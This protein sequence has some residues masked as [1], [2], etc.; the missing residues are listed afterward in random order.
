MNDTTDILLATFNGASH[1]AAQLDSLL[2]QTEA[3][4]RLLVR[5]DGSS[6]ATPRIIASYRDRY[7]ERIVVIDEGGERLGPAGNFARLLGVATAGRI[8]FC[9]QDDVW[10][11]EKIAVTGRK[12][13]ELEGAAGRET[14]LLVH[15]DLA[16]VDGELRPLAP[17]LWRFQ[18]VDPEKGGGLNRLLVQNCATGCTVMI[19]RALRDLALPIPPG[20]MMHDWWLALV[21]AAFGRIGHVPEPTV[22]YRQHGANDTGARR[23]S[24]SA[25]A[26]QLATLH[27]TR[28]VI[29]RIEGQAGAF[30]ER[31]GE[32]LGARDREMVGV[33]ARFRSCGFLRKRYYLVKYGLWYAGVLRN[34]G[35]LLFV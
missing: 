27:E 17:S 31:Y 10:L 6:D 22:L 3:S 28:A 4:W 33:A 9:D 16:V 18:G 11:P 2:S 7:P 21:A 25:L 13:T 26:A 20:A 14:P 24:V 15:T 1:L 29:A 30:S 23:L 19:N 34:L 5:D 32:R 35:R 12:M 8:M